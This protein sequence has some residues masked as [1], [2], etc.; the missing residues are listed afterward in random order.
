[1]KAVGKAYEVAISSSGTPAQLLAIEVT[2]GTS[3]KRHH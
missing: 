3:W 2:V 1:M